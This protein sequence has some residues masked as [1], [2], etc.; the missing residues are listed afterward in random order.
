VSVVSGVGA[1]F[2]SELTAARAALA[3]PEKR[4]QFPRDVGDK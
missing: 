3:H 1:T 4:T 2:T